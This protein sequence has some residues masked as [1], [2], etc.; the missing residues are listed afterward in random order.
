MTTTLRIALVG[1]TFA[2][3]RTVQRARAMRRLGHR[4][5]SIPTTPE[6]ANYET[7]PTLSARIRYR[8][9]MPAD[10]AGTNAALIAAA[11]DVDLIWL[12]AA[13]M[14]TAK[15]LRTAK[16]INPDIRIVTYSE[17]DIINPRHRS[18]QQE[19]A[20]PL[21]DLWATT[22]SFNT[23]ASELPSLG[24]RHTLF[25]DNGFDRDLHKAPDTQPDAIFDVGFIGTYEAPRAQSLRALARA[26]L[27]VNIWGNGWGGLAD[28]D[29]NLIVHGHPVYN[30]DYVRTIL[31]TKI[32]LCFLRH[33][34]RD[35]QT[36]R[37]VE[38]PACGGFML[39]EAS[40][41]WGRHY[42]DGIESVYFSDDDQ[43]ISLC[44]QW[45]RQNEERGR[46]AT[47][48]AERSRTLK[49]SHEDIV[50][51]ILDKSMR[52]EA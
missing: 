35:L 1:Q 14:V 51:T 21:I 2:A 23:A 18:R 3:S 6:G 12:E 24:V 13:G 25:V 41:E 29:A 33:G 20:F 38:I 16:T 11:K 26:G 31:S 45:L 9:R 42:R 34:N 28:T 39:H 37:S 4:V 47:A 48:A 5:I 52:Q 46:I 15:A 50:Q 44:R 30:E 40:D 49:L 27:S 32:N 17:D 22:K 10:L 7:P 19:A 8:L 43:L 36:C